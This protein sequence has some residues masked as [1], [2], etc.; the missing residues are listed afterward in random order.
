[1]DRDFSEYRIEEERERRE[2][3]V[4]TEDI[5]FSVIL[6]EDG[7][8]I[9]K[10][11][12]K[13]TDTGAGTVREDGERYTAVSGTGSTEITTDV[14]RERDS[15][16]IQQKAVC[17]SGIS[18]VLFRLRLD[19]RFRV[20]VPAWNGV[21]LSKEHPKFWT[22]WT[23]RVVYGDS[24]LQMQMLLLEADTGGM[25]IYA[26]DDCTQFKAFDVRYRD[27]GFDI[28]IETIPQAP[29]AKISDFH[30]VRWRFIPYHGK[31]YAGAEIYR[32]YVKKAFRLE[33][34][35]KSRPAFTEEISLVVLTDM[36]D[37]SELD[38][39]ARRVDPKKT[40]LHVPGWRKELYD[41]NWPDYT[42]RDGMREDIDYAHSLGFRVQ[43]HCNMNGCQMERQEY[44]RFGSAHSLKPFGEGK[45]NAD[46]SDARR[47]YLFAQI[48]P[49]SAEWRNFMTARLAA[50]ARELGAD[51]IH[52][53]ESLMS[54]NDG[55]GYR[56][57][58]TSLQGNVRYHEEL[59]HR[60]PDGVSIGGEGITD[61]NARFGTFQQSHVYAVDFAEGRYILD[62]SMAEQIVPLTAAVYREVVSYQWPGLPT[63]NREEEYLMWYL[64]GTAIG[65]IP[66]LMR[67]S[68]YSL[69]GGATAVTEM[70]LREAQ[71]YAEQRP[72]KCFENWEEGVLMRWKL[73]DGSFAVF[74]R[75]GDSY[76]LLGNEKDPSSVISHIGFDKNGIL[77]VLSD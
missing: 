61:F 4:R 23:S 2:L 24:P 72:V 3:F 16:F 18:G 50:A 63:T 41:V 32:D 27:G 44:E 10:A 56:D 49:A 6:S 40:L 54:G 26:E 35:L 29:F 33:E 46:F 55:G 45:V 70:V 77:R 64:T 1:M 25:L 76:L 65:H 20:L 13:I 71:W 68:A 57:G 42:P 73:K 53:D 36:T 31:W 21:R 38:A 15:F 19:D 60:L 67:E 69:T 37:R 52:L 22:G 8:R 11:D 66:T 30:T 74:R 7:N 34:A 47:H 48:N 58:L 9:R 51:S 14:S 12:G 28:D 17:E 5:E 62:R 59:A 43:L 39:L 75:E